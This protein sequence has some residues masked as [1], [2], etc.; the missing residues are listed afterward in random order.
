M[1]GRCGRPVHGW[2]LSLQSCSLLQAFP[3]RKYNPNS[4]KPQEARQL[5]TPL[6]SS[7]IPFSSCSFLYLATLLVQKRQNQTT[8]AT[9]P[10]TAPTVPGIASCLAHHGALPSAFSVDGPAAALALAVH[11]CPGGG[12][13]ARAQVAGGASCPTTAT[14]SSSFRHRPQHKW[15]TAGPANTIRCSADAAARHHSSGAVT[16]GTGTQGPTDASSSIYSSTT[17]ST[18]KGSTSS[19]ACTSSSPSPSQRR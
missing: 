12:R 19:V 11:C 3:A 8:T 16:P 13:A 10:G 6:H 5:E 4:P 18:H 9:W 2:Y 14:A 15:H 7:H 1:E 17:P